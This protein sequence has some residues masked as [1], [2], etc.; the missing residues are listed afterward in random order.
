MESFLRLLDERPLNKI[1]VKDIVDDC[2]IN[3]NTFYYHFADMPALIEAI[4]KDDIGQIMREWK[5]IDSLEQCLKA[6]L[7][8]THEHRRAVYHIYSSA[9]RDLVERYLMEI[10]GYVA[11][12]FVENVSQGIAAKPDDKVAIIQFYKCEL[13]G[14]VTDW[15]NH[16]M[17]A[18]MQKQFFRLCQLCAGDVQ[19]MLRRSAEGA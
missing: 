6:A 4:L 3:R 19:Q 7:Q 11:S 17:S 1:S 14:Q 12:A 18:D 9:N 15:L 2:G 5:S 10:C 13:F 16:G 8:M